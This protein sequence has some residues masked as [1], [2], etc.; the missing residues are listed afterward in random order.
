MDMFTASIDN[1]RGWVSQA[2]RDFSRAE[3]RLPGQAV[4]PTLAA[5]TFED[6]RTARTTI[7]SAVAS[8][9]LQSDRG[10]P[11]TGAYP[12]AL[13]DTTKAVWHLDQATEA[14]TRWWSGAAAAA[15][16]ATP[17]DVWNHLGAATA[18]LDRAS[19]PPYRSQ[20]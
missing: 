6:L 17:F 16:G 14:A 13:S 8:A 3:Q 20:G 19:C 15:T 9:K 2:D 12:D 18:F 11:D 4:D 10:T 7:E 5:A 1:V